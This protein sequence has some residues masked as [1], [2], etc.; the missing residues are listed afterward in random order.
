MNIYKHEFKMHFKSVIIW[1]VAISLLIFFVMSLFP[2]FADEA[3]I[4]N[5]MLANFPEE[6]LMAFGMNGVDMSTV[7]GFFSI[8]FLFAQICVA[9]QA[10]NYGFSLVSVEETDMTADF[11]LAKPIG[12]KKILTSKLLS[13]ISSLA[14]TTAVIWT[15]SIIFINIFSADRAYETGTLVLLLLTVPF[16]QLFFL[17]VGMLISLLV[18][19]IRSVT[20]FSLGL[21]F[22]LYVL[23]AFGGMVGGDTLSYI[24]PFKHFEPNYIVSNAAYDLPMVLISVTAIVLSVVGSYR[25][26]TKRDIH[27]AT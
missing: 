20:P 4:L 23:N 27:S 5:E 2:T 16:L 21:V 22:G 6:F 15:S 10:A 1:S 18:K 7:L 25:L 8:Y 9:I 3:E 11:L 12:R 24:T 14:L 26:Y 19:R 17:T 13:A